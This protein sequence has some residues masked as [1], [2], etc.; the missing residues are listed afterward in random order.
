[1]N[2]RVFHFSTT[3]L[4]LLICLPIVSSA[5][6]NLTSLDQEFNWNNEDET[7]TIYV[8]IKKGAD[9]IKMHF[10]GNIS[11]GDLQVTAY[12]PEG[13]KVSGF[14]LVCSNSDSGSTNVQ[15][16]TSGGTNVN[17]GSGTN[18]NIV[19]ESD[20]GNTVT[21]ST[22]GKVKSKNKSKSKHKHK[23]VEKNGK[24]SYSVTSTSSNNKG[25]KGVMGKSITDPAPGKWK[26]VIEVEGVTGSL[27]AE[28]EQY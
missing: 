19:V 20:T 5:Q 27:D 2:H 12:D 22:T 23:N 1:M 26:F 16:Q 3:I 24:G 8:D 10:E 15:V 6:D 21:V 13:N 17:I 11:Q 7:K 9:K 28:V 18:N 25:A 14:T 4:F